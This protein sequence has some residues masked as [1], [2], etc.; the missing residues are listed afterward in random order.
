MGRKN[1]TLTSGKGFVDGGPIG[2][3]QCREIGAE[4]ETQGTPHN[5]TLDG[6]R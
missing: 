1:Y 3:M 6:E 4:L 5:D 2:S